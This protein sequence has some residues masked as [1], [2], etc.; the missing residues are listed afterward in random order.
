[1]TSRPL[2]ILTTLVAF[3]GVL[4]TGLAQAQVSSVLSALERKNQ[5]GEQSQER[6]DGVVEQTRS[7]VDQY[8]TVLKETDGLV[9][10]NRLLQ[11]QI[12]DQNEQIAQLE[13]SIDEITVIERQIM[14]LMVRMIDGLDEFVGLD[15]PFLEEERKG[16][17]N[18]LRDLLDRADVSV[19]EKFRKVMEAYQIENDYGRTIEK[20]NGTIPGDAGDI[21]VEF[22]R[23]G[24]VALIYQTGDRSN[25]GAWDQAERK[26]QPLDGSYNTPVRNGIQIADKKK[27]PDLVT[28]PISA[29]EG[30]Q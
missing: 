27:A 10:Y 4:A 22:L 2:R 1:M 19:A 21:D 8:K 14:P 11:R 6:I 3:C 25:T 7:L 24:R 16:R 17:V 18:N 23:V 20:Y 29:P 28:L 15:V 12:D 26:W 5:A 30:A 13:A 9:V